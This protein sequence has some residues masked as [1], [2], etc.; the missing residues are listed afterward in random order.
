MALFIINGVID[1]NLAVPSTRYCS[2]L[3]RL[4]IRSKSVLHASHV[5]T[6]IGALLH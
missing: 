6:V 3:Y 4:R 2:T 1:A 5:L